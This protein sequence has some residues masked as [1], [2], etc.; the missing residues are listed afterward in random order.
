MY[1]YLDF[2]ELSG[3]MMW[4]NSYSTTLGTLWMSGN[5]AISG[6]LGSASFGG[7]GDCDLQGSSICGAAPI[8]CGIVPK[9]PPPPVIVPPPPPAPA[10]VIVPP[11]PPAPAPVPVIVPA[12]H[13]PAPAPV[14]VPPMLV[15]FPPPDHVN[16]FSPLFDSPPT[17]APRVSQPGSSPSPKPDLLFV[18]GDADPGYTQHPFIVAL[19]AMLI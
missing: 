10:P 15:P 16:F 3:N 6:P 2:N 18:G 9:C 17:S 14:A 12:P 13:P 11:P 7:I 19:L 5:V 1:R 8:P 4:I